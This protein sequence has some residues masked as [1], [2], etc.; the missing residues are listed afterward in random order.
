MGF[1]S[2]PLGTL[3]SVYLRDNRQTDE[4]IHMVSHALFHARFL[5]QQRSTRGVREYS[6]TYDWVNIAQLV[7]RAVA[8]VAAAAVASLAVL[9]WNVFVY[10]MQM[11]VCVCESHF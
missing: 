8:F 6:G 9:V 2:G 1:T 7:L 4:S 11:C 10:K 5:L 3:V